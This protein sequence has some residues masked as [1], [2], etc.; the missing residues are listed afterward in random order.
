MRISKYNAEGYY[1]PTTYDALT[2]IIKEERA[3]KK[4]AFKPLVYICSPYSGDVDANVIKARL[5]C[6]FA[7]NQNCI[8]LAP[9]LLF[10]QFMDDGN[11]M[12]RE[13]AMFM[14]IVLMGKCSEVWVL[15]NIISNG[16]AE[17]IAKARKRKQTVR[18]FNEKYEEVESL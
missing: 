8:P 2:N 5:F 17:E 1:D 3:E 14:D 7:I 4:S 9:H 13:L 15:G 18:Y 10:P 11:P 6:R 12:E 16:M